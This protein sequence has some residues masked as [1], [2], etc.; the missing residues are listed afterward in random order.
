MHAYRDTVQ[1]QL[2]LDFTEEPKPAGGF[3]FEVAETP[4]HYR[5]VRAVSEDELVDFS[6]AL[7]SAR[8]TREDL[9]DNPNRTKQYFIL[10][11]A[12][13]PHEVFACAF[14]DNRLR[15]IAYEE[16]FFGTIDSCSVHPRSVLCRALYHNAAGVMLAHNHPS[17]VADPSSADRTLTDRLKSTLSLCDIRVMDHIVVGGGDAI[18][19]AD[20]GL[21]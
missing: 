4:H 10:H 13:H 7:L 8:F 15:V 9:L 12:R 18:S 17:G 21:L 6:C 14:L 5:I 3:P 20:R 2:T 11:L 1:T 16:L 19:F